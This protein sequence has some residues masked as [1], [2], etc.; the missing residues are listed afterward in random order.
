MK[1]RF[2]NLKVP[3]SHVAQKF[4]LK[5]ISGTINEVLYDS[6]KRTLYFFVDVTESDH[7][8]IEFLENKLSE[9]FKVK[10]NI[11]NINHN[12]ETLKNELLKLLN[13]NVPYVKDIEIYESKI[14]IKTFSEFSAAIIK[15]KLPSINN[16]LRKEVL[17]EIEEQKEK[18]ILPSASIEAPKITG[19]V[20]PKLNKKEVKYYTPSNIDF[21]VKNILLQGKVFNIEVSEYG[22][23]VLTVYITDKKNSIVAKAFDKNAIK[24][25]ELLEQ[26]KW[27]FFKGTINT[28]KNG[29]MYFQIKEAFI[30]D[31]PPERIDKYPV[32]RIELH[33]HSKMSDLDAI[34]DISDY[35]KKAAQWGWKAIAITDHGNV[36]AIPYLFEKATAAGIKPIFGTE[37][38]VLNEEGDIVKN[39]DFEEEFENITFTVFDLET[40]GT[41]AKFDEIIEIG[42]VK[43]KNG[44]IIDKFSA[45]IKPS[46]K[47]SDFTKKLTGITNEMLENERSIQEVF[48]EFLR[49]IEGTVL[50]AHNAEFDY[51]FVREWYRKLFHKEFYYVYIDTLKLARALLKNK[52]KSFGLDKLVEYFN[53]GSFKHHRALED[54]TVTAEIFN[55]LL[56]LA[57]K[58]GIKT[59]RQLNNLKNKQRISNIRT[60]HV[61]NHITILVQN[62]KGLKN[63]Y[64]LV[65]DA[66][67]KY[68]KYVP[69]VPKNVL[70]KYKDGLLFGTG[71]ENGEVFKSLT[72]SA[73]DEEI[74]EILKDY[75]YVEIFPL[76]TISTIDREQAK[77]VYKRLY[78]LAKRLNLPVV[79]AGNVHYIDPE[80]IKGRHVLLSP[81]ESD[82]PND[83][84]L[85]DKNSNYFLRTTEE[86]IDAAFE[87]FESEE[88]AEE[89]VIKNPEIINEMIENITPVKKQ[90]NPPIIEGADEKVK[91]LSYQK[92][93]EIYGKPLPEKI[94]ERLEKELK[95]IIDHGYAVL[96]EIAHL[97]VKKAN[98]D[99]YVVGSRG[100][101]G[102][103]FVA[104][105]MGITEVNPLPPHYLCKNCKYIEFFEDVG[106]GYDL[107]DK[108]CPNCGTNLSKLGQDIPF[109]VFMGFHGDKIPDIDLN[110]SGEYQ[111][112]AHKYIVEL[113][114]KDNV[115]RA[116][117]I[118]TIAERSAIGYVKSYAE[119]TGEKINKAEMRRLANMVTGVKRT[120]GQHP[121]GLMIVPKDKSVYDF[122]PIQYPA[123]K[124]DS[125]MC[126]THFAYE[127]IHDDLVKL[128]ALGHDDPTML[129]LL[130]EYTG[131]DPT[132]IPMDDR[133]TLKIF[134]SLQPL[135]IKPSDL[136]T[137]VGTIGI[138]EFGTSFVQEMLK[139]TRPKTFSELVRISG[140]SHGTDVWLNN[141]QEIIRSKKATL[142]EVISC[143][144]DIMNYLIHHGIDESTSF[145]IM[146][147]V[148]KGKGITEDEEK[149]MKKHKVPEWFINSCKKIKYLF[150]KAH[151]VA[152]VSM[153]F[154]IAYFKVHYPLAYY[155][156][157]FSIK[158]DEFNTELIL[159]GPT[160]IKKRLVEL[161][162]Q[163]KKDVK[164]KSEEKVL[165]AA[166]E[167]YLR[168]FSFLP[169]DIIKSDYKKFIIENKKLRIPLNRIPG[170]GDNVALSIINARKEKIFTSIDD[171]KRRTKLSK[172]HLQT[173]KKLKLLEDL[174]ETDQQTLF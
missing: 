149:L 39:L 117:T 23:T 18:A 54:A 38:Y 53:V 34:L 106:S 109:E 111:D 92:A 157:F 69:F 152:Y 146:E 63:L 134:S 171:L 67:I 147:K 124:K 60:K 8:K 141:A 163:L 112:K 27:Y 6:R 167:M 101:V 35:V 143:R 100:S 99:G 22:K 96:Y 173:M 123:N 11:E 154:R 59:I 131:I 40:T 139:E 9:F 51:G 104:Y 118:S 81:K 94:K 33:A 28:D 64:H 155:A 132:T 130:K 168:G 72:G 61:F 47:I 77:E 30:D 20:L 21:S 108:K 103:S 65:S 162:S 95:S 12:S 74:I 159:R 80:D 19:N 150:P 164:E 13:G 44:K 42:A 87:I 14:I 119:L 43:Y 4:D 15:Q 76:D 82:K 29:E 121:G 55:K 97:I 89:V 26:N 145:K 49:F 169:P 140:L 158:G 137:D 128:D 5:N 84:D 115:Y 93:I 107:P 105:L 3:I 174:P 10:T 52:I 66:H 2:K 36:Q 133:K 142:K 153:A 86:M 32:K 110:F 160:H 31:S 116:G 78:N 79:M 45:L 71:C 166:L 136:G 88:I 57:I 46:K 114:G 172:A 48:P 144:D 170:I 62:K 125:E 37:M 1:Y 161:K 148:R 165:E 16:K 135:K 85:K 126:T 122:T 68:F 120:T 102:S 58:R 50:V 24:L 151:A 25:L 138:P 91:R 156:A 75:N 7:K 56:D 113:F 41:N 129:K 90:L 127:S 70:K 98:E 17:I 83:E 73:T